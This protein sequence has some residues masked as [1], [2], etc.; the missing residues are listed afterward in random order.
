MRTYQAI[1]DRLEAFHHL[2]H[3]ELAPIF[4]RHGSRLVGRWQ[5]VD[6]QIIVAI[7]EYDNLEHYQASDAAA[8]SDPAYLAAM[9]RANADGPLYA[10]FQDVLMHAT[11]P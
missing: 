4:E 2:F 1:P 8:R 10:S 11:A 9:K 7:F 6:R 5:D 3:Q